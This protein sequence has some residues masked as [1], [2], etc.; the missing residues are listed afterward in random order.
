MYDLS[1]SEKAANLDAF[2]KDIARQCVQIDIMQKDLAKGKI[3]RGAVYTV[4]QLRDVGFTPNPGHSLT[5]P[6]E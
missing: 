4:R 2:A 5:N 6:K 3:H 1:P